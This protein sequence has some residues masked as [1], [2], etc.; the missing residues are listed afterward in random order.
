[1]ADRTATNRFQVGV[2]TPRADA[3]TKVT[4]SEQFAADRYG[5]DFLWAGVKRSDVPHARVRAI[6]TRDAASLPGVT[7][8]LTHGDVPGPNR[9]GIVKRDQ[10]VLVDGKIR[11][12][13][14]ALALVIAG[15]RE[16]LRRALSLITVDC[17]PLPAVF[18]PERALS[19][20]APLIHEDF[21]DGN[22]LDDMEVLHGDVDR[23]FAESDVIVEWRYETSR[24][25]H[26]F[27]ETETGWARLLPDGELT[28]VAST[29]SPFRD[30]MEIA[31]ALGM[32][33]GRIRVVAPFLG[34]GFGGK[35]G[36]NVQC[37]LAVAALNS[38]GRPVKMW[39]DRE[40]SFVA[41]VK[42]MPA[43]MTY[44][45][46]AKS[47]GT[48]HALDCS[49]VMDTGPYEHLSGEILAL[50]VE[51]AGG[52]YRFPHTRVRGRCVYTNNPV[53]GPFRGFGV[54]Q[55][56]AAVEQAVDLLAERLD[57]DPL[58]L[59]LKN[60][61]RRG[62]RN[63]VGVTLVNSVSVHECLEKMAE[64]PAWKERQAWKSAAGKHKRRGVGLACLLQ[65]GGYGPV[66]PDVGNAQ[67][68]LTPEGTFRVSC[69]VSDMGQGNASTFVQIAGD[70]L[71]Q[72]STA[73]AMILPDTGKTLPSGS[74]AAGR[75]TY[76]YANALIKAA[77]GLAEKML[78]RAAL[79]F[80]TGS[81]EDLALLPGKVVHLPSGRE[82]PLSRLAAFMGP[83]ERVST[84]Y[85]KAPT[86]RDTLRIKSK[87]EFMGIPHAIFS[88]AAHAAWVE[89]DE[90]TGR[91]DVLRYAAVS[92]CGGVIN[93]QLYEQQ[94][95][96]GI[97]QGL[98]FALFEE[99]P[100]RE[101]RQLATDLSTYV[102]PSTLDVP[103]MESVAIA[104]FEE[105]GPYGLKGAGE[106]PING[107][108]PAVANGVADG[109]GVRLET[110]PVTAEKVLRALAGKVR[111]QV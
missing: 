104:G 7:A 74:A 89:V 11:R 70:I 58:R 33:P 86:A 109:C 19:P 81:V 73:L 25:A 21:P 20:G 9:Q 68:E 15:D 75:T 59:R 26:A 51:H 62:D 42:R 102:I 87:A 67:V 78:Q 8:V 22:L 43:W 77:K 36:C 52:A 38:H 47:D 85:W 90:L 97:A 56:T 82:L 80:M 99:L 96:G 37:L 61:V 98:G 103:D 29:Q 48:F 84:G 63:A 32:D 50:A 88:Y 27:L 76:T 91:V 54:P 72:E 94:I 106:I 101:G 17:E 110:S 44:R 65:A 13:G 1:M 28:V 79:A 30:R 93:P 35:D 60:V 16:I 92:D 45:V 55:V 64:H 53:G 39:W 14:D 95:Q 105:T 66:I 23:G 31:H 83:S 69:G 57:M 4:G 40:E 5:D 6:H 3:W 111:R 100:V 12:I 46:G 2:S 107:P 108:L 10:P 18:D 34:G 71:R 24:Q 49:I 41:G